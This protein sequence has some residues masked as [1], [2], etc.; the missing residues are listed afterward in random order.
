MFLPYMLCSMEV[1]M[2]SCQKILPQTKSM[3]YIL[4]D[5]TIFGMQL[6]AFSVYYLSV[7]NEIFKSHSVSPAIRWAKSK[8]LVGPRFIQEA[9]NGHLGA[10][11]YLHEKGILWNDRVCEEAAKNGRLDIL[12]YLHENG[13]RWY[14]RTCAAAAANGHPPASCRLIA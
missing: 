4:N 10:L 3:A 14:W 1:A 2:K 13:C 11:K 12:K 9:A 6:N 7:G 8:R 5:P